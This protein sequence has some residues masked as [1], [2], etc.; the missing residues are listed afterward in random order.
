MRRCAT[1]GA[2]FPPFVCPTPCASIARWP[3]A[4]GRPFTDPAVKP[5]DIAFLQYTGGTTGVPKGAMLT[6]RNMV[7]NLR[8]IHAWVAPALES[9]SETF[10]A[11]LPLYHVFSLQVN[12]FV[13]MMIGATNLLIANPR[14][15]PG[16]VK[17]MRGTPFTALPGVNTLFNALLNN[18]DFARLDF[19]RLHFAIGG[20][21]G[22]AAGGRRALAAG[23]RQAAD[24]SLRADRDLARGDRQSAGRR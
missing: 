3:W 2:T 5:D 18:T 22:G 23:D 13:P 6:H 20:R 8:Q 19:S 10:V 16:L 24:R 9:D 21:H 12:G 17:A 14:D 4:R 15:I 11:A 7:A 1:S